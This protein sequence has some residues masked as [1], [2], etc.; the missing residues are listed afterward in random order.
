MLGAPLVLAGAGWGV[1][2]AMAGDE[3]PR[4]RIRTD[5]EPLN[6]R[7]APYTGE[8]PA[9][10]WQAYDIDDHG[11]RFTLPSPDRRVRVV[12]VARLGPGGA[13]RAMGDGSTF[14][15]AVPR[16]LPGPLKPHLPADA[17]WQRSAHFDTLVAESGTE[18]AGTE[19]PGAESSG[20]SEIC[21]DAQ[22]DLMYFDLLV[23]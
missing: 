3:D 17:Q 6:A 16:D 11:D 1:A 23:I 21:I 14:F 15:A 9:A 10:H 5:L 19:P 8:L 12:G 22:R 20:T 18:P 13:R 4:R 2:A 7:F